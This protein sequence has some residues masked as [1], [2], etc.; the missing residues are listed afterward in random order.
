MNRG[1]SYV[2]ISGASIMVLSLATG[3]FMQQTLKTTV[4]Q[5]PAREVNGSMINGTVAAAFRAPATADLLQC[6]NRKMCPAPGL[7]AAM[8]GGLTNPGSTASSVLFQC[9]T[10]NC[11]FTEHNGVTYS[12]IAYCS[13]CED[14]TE[15]I[16]EA[17]LAGGSDFND[18]QAEIDQGYVHYLSAGEENVT[19]SYG[20]VR[21]SWLTV[22]ASEDE[23][24][25]ANFTVLSFTRAGCQETANGDETSVDCTGGSDSNAAQHEANPFLPA[26]LNMVAAR[27]T[28]RPCLRNYHGAVRNGRL[29]ETVVSRTM[30]N[31][32]NGR[33]SHNTGGHPGKNI[34]VA[35][36]PCLVDG[37]WYDWTNF[38]AVPRRP[39]RNF[40][41][42]WQDGHGADVP[43]E[44]TYFV[45]FVYPG[46]LLDFFQAALNGSCGTGDYTSTMSTQ[47]MCPEA[48]WML[49]PLWRDGQATLAS[50]ADVLEG[51]ATAITNRLRNTGAAAYDPENAFGY[52]NATGPALVGGAAWETTV[53]T[54]V[55]WPWIALPAA[56]TVATA[57][58]LAGVAGKSWR[59]R[60]ARPVW[61]ASIL[62]L[63]FHGPRAET[64]A[65]GGEADSTVP[66]ATLGDMRQV[67]DGMHVKLGKGEVDMVLVGMEDEKTES[68]IKTRWRGRASRSESRLD[69]DSLYGD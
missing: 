29:E 16:K 12:S 51:L 23:W 48:S 68:S 41:S 33:W 63:L 22:R 45:L 43:W 53:C 1:T 55:E 38:T 4:C 31:G 9:P 10:G 64:R 50:T 67:A 8:A 6:G 44:C 11:T 25:S 65:R 40:T 24:W 57:V 30:A 69:V 36:S 13:S 39:G 37:A 61:K 21:N 5:T 19:I 60:A 7:R 27:C 15:D 54:R 46:A 56:L 59:D 18:T 42:L 52:Y 62:P 26:D 2:A 34:P 49:A 58:L 20:D 35:Q 14:V 32:S 47:P 17:P 3:S 28:V 66:L